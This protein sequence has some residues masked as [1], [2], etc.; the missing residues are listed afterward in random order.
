MTKDERLLYY[1]TGF[2]E[3]FAKAMRVI[4]IMAEEQ[5]GAEY[6]K[7]I[8]DVEVAAHPRS[9]PPE[10]GARLI[11]I[12]RLL[13]IWRQNKNKLPKF[14]MYRGELFK[15]VGED[16]DYVCEASDSYGYYPRLWDFISEPK[17]LDEVVKEVE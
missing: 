7:D 13:Q 14:I 11:S 6:C 10:D 4:S 9:A 17:V 8:S 16:D 12:E 2:K 1:K 15:Y 5:N 3:G